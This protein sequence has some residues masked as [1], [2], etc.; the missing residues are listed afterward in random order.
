MVIDVIF[1]ADRQYIEDLQV[2]RAESCTDSGKDSRN[3]GDRTCSAEHLDSEKPGEAYDA[4]IFK[5]PPSTT[6]SAACVQ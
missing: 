2:R 4:K 6:G 3:N 1:F 5:S